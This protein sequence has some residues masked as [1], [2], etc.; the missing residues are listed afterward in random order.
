MKCTDDGGGIVVTGN[1][2][3]KGGD[4]RPLWFGGVLSRS[5]RLGASSLPLEPRM[6]ALSFR[7]GIWSP[8]RPTNLCGASQGAL[9]RASICA[10][11]GMVAKT[12]MRTV[13]FRKM[14]GRGAGCWR[15]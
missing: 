13:V 7:W 6:S 8:R 14:S 3:L 4:E 12:E 2:L 9:V 15:H 1:K 5:R 11:V 10:C